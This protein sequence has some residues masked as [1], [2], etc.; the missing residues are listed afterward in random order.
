MR[1]PYTRALAIAI[2][3]TLLFSFS[4]ALLTFTPATNQ[5]ANTYYFSIGEIFIFHF[6]YMIVP[7]VVGG[8]LSTLLSHMT[9]K[10]FV[11]FKKHSYIAHLLSHIIGAPIVAIIYIYVLTGGTFFPDDLLYGRLFAIAITGS[12][13]Y[14][15]MYMASTKLITKRFFQ[16]TSS[17]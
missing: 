15:H 1:H 11:F 7:F 12:L 16:P 4:I 13:L 17:T 5:A 3:S 8:L 6:I 10:R 14:F 2:I 9:M